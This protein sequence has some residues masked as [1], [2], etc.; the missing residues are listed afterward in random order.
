MTTDRKAVEAATEP[1]NEAKRAH[2]AV[3]DAADA[4]RADY[5]SARE[6][7]TERQRALREQIAEQEK[8]HRAQ[9]DAMKH[10]TEDAQ[11][12][13]SHIDE[14]TD[15]HEH[16]EVTETLAGALERDR[17]ELSEQMA[18]VQKLEAAE[19]RVR[20]STHDSRVKFLGAIAIAAAI[21]VVAVVAWLILK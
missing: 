8:A 12:A 11:A 16:P 3:T 6:A 5:Q 7:S 2:Q 18:E 1:I 9:I 14:A 19:Q 17:N 20:E 10:A 13:Q 21:I 15:V 4:A